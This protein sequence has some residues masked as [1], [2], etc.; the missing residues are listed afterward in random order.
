MSRDHSDTVACSPQQLPGGT[1]RSDFYLQLGTQALA[2][3]NMHAA[4]DRLSKCKT[5]LEGQLDQLGGALVNVE[6][7]STSLQRSSDEVQSK[8]GP[9]PNAG[10]K[11][12]PK[13]SI[14][15]TS[16]LACQLGAVLG[17]QA[18]CCRRIGDVGR[19]VALYAQS[20][21]VLTPF[22]AD[23]PEVRVRVRGKRVSAHPIHDH[24]HCSPVQ[25]AHSLSITN[26]KRGDLYYYQQVCEAA[27]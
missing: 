5:D 12:L 20:V 13:R 17:L 4:Y 10:G 22:A 16:R 24:S 6:E 21:D 11:S 14:S 23:D 27:L 26:N 15:S 25:V 2:G 1:S 7:G 8:A 9:V 18:D 3:G 19:A